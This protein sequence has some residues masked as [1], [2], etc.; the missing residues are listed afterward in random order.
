MPDDLDC[1]GEWW[2]PSDPGKVVRGRLRHDEGGRLGLYP[3]G[4]LGRRS[5]R[6]D[7]L[8]EPII[9]GK[10]GDGRKVTLADCT[11]ANKHE[12]AGGLPTSQVVA[13]L[14]FRGSQH[15]DP[16]ATK[17]RSIRAHFPYTDAW[18]ERMLLLA[19][20]AT[21]GVT[22]AEEQPKLLGACDSYTVTLLTY[23]GEERRSDPHPTAP[24]GQR[25]SIGLDF[26]QEVLY[27]EA[28]SALGDIQDFLTFA[29]GRPTHATDIH[30]GQAEAGSGDVEVLTRAAD[31][32]RYHPLHASQM[33]LPLSGLFVNGTS[34]LT[35]WLSSIGHLRYVYH[36]YCRALYNAG[37][38]S[39]DVEDQ[40]R[41]FVTALEC[42]HRS[43]RNNEAAPKEQHKARVQRILD[44]VAGEDRAWLARELDFS[45]EP[46]LQ[47]RLESLIAEAPTFASLV[48]DVPGF[49]KK[50][51]DNRNFLT[52]RDEDFARKASG[53]SELHFLTARL[54]ALLTMLLLGEIGATPGEIAP[55]G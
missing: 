47:Q 14:A 46:T 40:F 50:V 43:S 22:V 39:I 20:E 11:E 38:G 6:W 23:C 30:L 54:S 21:H 41:D 45:N 33:V 49:I 13:S 55:P 53:S 12:G 25:S 5:G 7:F 15:V 28:R 4:S 36:Q 37:A 3:D 31:R 34:R 1:H 9:L 18:A 16:A 10:S 42:Y 32:T 27:D 51:K 52:H 44:A 48:G 19:D 26:A 29:F 2:L 8:S 35:L 17:F 24:L